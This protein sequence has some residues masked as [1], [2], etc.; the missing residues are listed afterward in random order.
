MVSAF[1]AEMIVETAMVTANCRKNWPVMPVMKQQGMN[2]ELSAS[3]I[4]RIGPVISSIALIVA[5]RASSP[6]AII[7][8]VFSS[9][10]MASST[11]M[12]MASTSPKSVRLLR[13]KP[14]AAM[15][16]K[17]P[18][19]ET[20]TSIIGKIMVFQSWRKT[21]TTRPTRSTA[22]RRVLNTS[23]IDS[24]MYGVVS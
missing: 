9:T 16:A 21:S 13:V 8:S 17:V 14:R 20:G 15:T 1:T 10:T 23:R 2:T 11:T 24:R 19:K 3:V 5:V 18:I 12:P 22:S 7:R 6:L 4:A